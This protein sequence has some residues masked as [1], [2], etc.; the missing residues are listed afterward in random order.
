MV[1]NR[2]TIGGCSLFVFPCVKESQSLVSIGGGC[3][4][5]DCDGV[6]EV[7]YCFRV[8]TGSIECFAEIVKGVRVLRLNFQSFA[9]TGDGLVVL[10]FVKMVQA[11]V[12]EFLSLMG[13]V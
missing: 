7:S 13:D 8:V 9:K 10:L 5:S 2:L 4:R 3:F 12:V 1:L 6:V 11:A